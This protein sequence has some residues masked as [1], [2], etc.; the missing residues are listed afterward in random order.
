MKKSYYLA[1]AILGLLITTAAIGF[2]TLAASDN[3][4]PADQAGRREEKREIHQAIINNNYET[5]ETAM[6]EM[7]ADLR[8]KAD[9]MEAKIN[10]DTFNKLVLADQL[11]KDG[12]TDEAKAIFEELGMGGPG[13][14][15]HGGPRG[16]HQPLNDAASNRQMP[17]PPEQA[18]AAE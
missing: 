6:Q 15:G 14:M 1:S 2:T 12:K 8:A 18:P 7:V 13:P 16:N 17:Q 5:W 11:M 4:G 3:Q 10:Q 9:E